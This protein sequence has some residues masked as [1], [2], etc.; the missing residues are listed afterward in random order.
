MHRCRICFETTSE[1]DVYCKCK[2]S[3]KYIHKSCLENW[4]YS[5]SNSHMWTCEI[6]KQEYNNYNNY[7]NYYYPIVLFLFLWF[8]FWFIMWIDFFIYRC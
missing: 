5:R 3:I 2:G 7:N 4:I 1:N 8:I 6:C